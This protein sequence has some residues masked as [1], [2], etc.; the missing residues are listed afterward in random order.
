MRSKQEQLAGLMEL[1][2]LIGRSEC[3]AC[4]CQ[5]PGDATYLMAVDTPGASQIVYASGGYEV[6]TCGPDRLHLQSPDLSLEDAAKVVVA[7]Y[8]LAKAAR[9]RV[10]NPNMSIDTIMKKLAKGYQGK[11]KA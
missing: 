3:N 6:W 7:E 9:I 5:D 1:A 8:H 2:D 10:R 4:I 11:K